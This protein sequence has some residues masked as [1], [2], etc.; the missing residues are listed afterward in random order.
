ID[1]LNN[2]GDCLSELA[3]TFNDRCQK[4]V[5]PDKDRVLKMMDR[6]TGKV[7]V[8]CSM[9]EF[10]WD[11]SFFETYQTIFKLIEILDKKGRLKKEDIPLYFSS[12][13]DRA[14]RIA[15]EISYV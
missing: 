1:K 4:D 12:R 14:S 15:H 11:R 6:V 10:C 3:R 5:A 13:C 8:G 2:F 9:K 7:C